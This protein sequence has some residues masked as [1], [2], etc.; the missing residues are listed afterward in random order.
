MEDALSFAILYHHLIEKLGSLSTWC[1]LNEM[2]ND[3]YIKK[4]FG[5]TKVQLDQFHSE[6]RVIINIGCLLM[7]DESKFSK[8]NN[9]M[10]LS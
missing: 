10:K 9:E 4:V 6:I 8:N 1:C 3:D 7:A 5:F 2:E